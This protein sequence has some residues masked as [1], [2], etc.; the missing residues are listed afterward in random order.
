MCLERNE[1]NVL[2][3]EY[4][5][6]EKKNGSNNHSILAQELLLTLSLLQVLPGLVLL[7]SQQSLFLLIPFV[8]AAIQ[9]REIIHLIW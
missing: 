9:N 1:N 6:M 7:V 4:L 5:T 3:W 2:S 8:F